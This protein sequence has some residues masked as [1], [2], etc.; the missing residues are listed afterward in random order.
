MIPFNL[1]ASTRT[2]LGALGP[3][4]LKQR[5]VALVAVVG[6]QFASLERRQRK[7]SVNGRA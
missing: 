3:E 2:V 1:S 5:V 6:Q 4:R 7:D